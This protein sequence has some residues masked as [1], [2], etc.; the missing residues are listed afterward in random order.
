MI[1]SLCLDWVF[2]Y[3][4]TNILLAV[5]S[6]SRR[7]YIAA[8]LGFLFF[9]VPFVFVLNSFFLSF[10]LFL[11][12]QFLPI[13][14]LLTQSTLKKSCYRSQTLSVSK[15]RETCINKQVGKDS[16]ITSGSN[17]KWLSSLREIKVFGFLE[18]SCWYQLRQFVGD[19]QG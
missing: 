18:M 3:I 11:E 2:F 9:V 16:V 1:D 6:R 14:F 13:L 10:F 12:G 19:N 17:P 4:L 7:A 5:I 8:L 15:P